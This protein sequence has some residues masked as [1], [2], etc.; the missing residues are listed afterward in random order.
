MANQLKQYREEN[1][2]HTQSMTK[3]AYKISLDYSQSTYS[4]MWMIG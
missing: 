4:A 1:K 2:W 3:S